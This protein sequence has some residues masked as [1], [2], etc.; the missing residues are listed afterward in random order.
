MDRLTFCIGKFASFHGGYIYVRYRR[1]DFIKYSSYLGIGDFMVISS[2][3]KHNYI[4]AQIVD[5]YDVIIDREENLRISIA[6]DGSITSTEMDIY[7]F[8]ELKL[9]PIIEF[10]TKDLV[11][12]GNIF[13]TRLK[14]VFLFDDVLKRDFHR[15]F[16][17][18]SP[19]VQVVNVSF[20]KDVSLY[21]VVFLVGIDDFLG[22][23]EN[24]YVMILDRHKWKNPYLLDKKIFF[25]SSSIFLDYYHDL[26]SPN[27]V[28]FV[29]MSTRTELIRIV[30][31]YLVPDF[32]IGK[33]LLKSDYD[34][35]YR[36]VP[37]RN[38]YLPCF[39]FCNYYL[40]HK[41]VIF[42]Y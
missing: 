34:I 40:I 5:I 33:N 39:S 24:S 31:K 13:T 2:V 27:R 12:R 14:E 18:V 29:K 35:I 10:N 17:S 23:S 4:L 1:N 25:V 36:L 8:I 38:D 42:C 28:I 20:L 26:K 15:V 21:G 30:N 41:G 9:K 32:I 6:N 37:I 22:I 3:N 19:K 16:F 11:T 7:L